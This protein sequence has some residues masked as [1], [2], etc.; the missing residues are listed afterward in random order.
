MNADPETHNETERGRRL[1]ESG[2][3]A[4]FIK[5]ALIEAIKERLEALFRQLLR[6]NECSQHLACA[7]KLSA[8]R[9][10]VISQNLAQTEPL[11]LWQNLLKPEHA[12]CQ[13]YQTVNVE[14]ILSSCHRSKFCALAGDQAKKFILR[15]LCPAPRIAPAGENVAPPAKG[16]ADAKADSHLWRGIKQLLA[17]AALAV[18]YM[19]GRSA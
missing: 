12:L 1:P 15:L 16:Q 10:L 9:V 18:G 19:I 17:V 2:L 11:G 13:G 7:T 5:D 8:G 14:N 4:L 6:L 3:L